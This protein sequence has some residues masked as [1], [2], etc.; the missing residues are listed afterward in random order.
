MMAKRIALFLL[1]NVLVISTASIIL[2]VLG[3]GSYVTAYG[4]DYKGLM[5]F[6]LIWGMAGSFISL[7]LSRWMAKTMM[8]VHVVSPTGSHGE[9]VRKVHEISRRAGL[10]TM[11]EVGIYESPVINAFA[12]GR[13]RNSSL[14]AVSTGL[15]NKMNTDERDGVLAHEVAHIANGD[16]ITMALLQGVIN[17]F[18]MFLARVVA[19]FI[20]SSMRSNDRDGHSGV[21]GFA[22]IMTVWVLEVVFGI[23][24]SVIVMAFSRW[25]EFRADAGSAALVGK[26]KMI[27]AL[28]ALQRDY[29]MMQETN[30]KA[31]VQTMSISSKGSFFGNLFSSHPALDDRIKALQSRP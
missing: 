21:G 6:C 15:L 2:N 25:R 30:Y 18:V 14:V 29:G 12:T 17:A 27:A 3:I 11:P 4:L 22:Y 13:S 23:M 24:A 20:Q 1:T 5:I 28:Q 7:S 16:M 9:L 8:G 31:N 26:S 10:T 19:Y